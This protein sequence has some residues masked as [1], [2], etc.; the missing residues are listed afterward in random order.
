MRQKEADDEIVRTIDE[1]G[2]DEAKY[3]WILLG[4]D[5]I[6][7]YFIGKDKIKEPLIKKEKK[8]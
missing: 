4:S 7:H 8:K 3:L 1:E 2:M 5:N 6:A